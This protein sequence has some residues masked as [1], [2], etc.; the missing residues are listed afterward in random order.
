VGQAAAKPKVQ[1]WYINAKDKIDRDICI[2]TQLEDIKIQPNRFEAMRMH[3]CA[4]GVDFAMCARK[5][6]MSDCVKGG[7]Q[8]G[9]LGSHGSGKEQANSD[10]KRHAGITS[11]WCSHKRLFSKI[12]EDKNSADYHLIFEDDVILKPGF[13]HAV[14]DFIENYNN[15]TTSSEWGQKWDMVQIDPFGATCDEHKVDEFRG[16]PI[17]K[18]KAHHWLR[19]M[20]DAWKETHKEWMQKN[21]C[22]EY[23]G[24]HALLVKRS[25]MNALVAN[26][27]S[28]PTV[29]LD[30]L[31]GQYKNAIA[32]KPGV[33]TNPEEVNVFKTDQERMNAADKHAPKASNLAKKL[34][35]PSYCNTDVIK[36]S[37]SGF[38]QMKQ[39]KHSKGKKVTDYPYVTSGIL[40]TWADHLAAD[41]RRL[42]VAPQQSATPSAV[43]QVAQQSATP[44]A[45]VQVAQQAK[46]VRHR[47][48]VHRRKHLKNLIYASKHDKLLRDP[49]EEDIQVPVAKDLKHHADLRVATDPDAQPLFFPDATVSTAKHPA[50]LQ[51]AHQANKT[52]P[53]HRARIHSPK[54]VAMKQ[55]AEKLKK[56]SLHQ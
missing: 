54:Y 7:L 27:E 42:A 50:L 35:L 23:W 43:I 20:T 52:M 29:P 15:S 6:Q 55:H 33:A 10:F 41:D 17:Y 47:Q 38:I 5:Q 25:A 4:P 51:V 3:T 13:K 46:K 37:L 1:A 9:A 49:D 22:N 40:H 2:R 56:M 44:S 32:W 34:Q 11:N 30:W 31:T 21:Q 26:M 53:A 18:P 39:S 45:V 16:N 24:F 19:D 14:A 8:Y 48:I 36:S 28:N 12:A